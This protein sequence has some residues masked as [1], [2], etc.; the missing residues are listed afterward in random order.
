MNTEKILAI[1]IILLCV[2]NI[3]QYKKISR[4]EAKLY[5]YEHGLVKGGLH[6]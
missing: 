6:D 5:C 1:F 3:V 2:I 4:L